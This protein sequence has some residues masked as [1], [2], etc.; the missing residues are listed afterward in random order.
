M[1]DKIVE[2]LQEL[3]V[4]YSA[5]SGVGLGSIQQLAHLK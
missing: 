3:K 4:S 5:Q 1:K 2:K